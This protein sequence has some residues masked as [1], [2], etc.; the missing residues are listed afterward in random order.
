[1]QVVGAAGPYAQKHLDGKREKGNREGRSREDREEGASGTGSQERLSI[2]EI[3]CKV[4]C[5]FHWATELFR[6][7]IVAPVRAPD[8]A[9]NRGVARHVAQDLT[10]VRV[11][12][13]PRKISFPGSQRH[14]DAHPYS[15]RFQQTT[16]NI[17]LAALFIAGSF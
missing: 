11:Y 8:T 12:R 16:L 7:I 17:P 1:M 13:L 9:R 5:Y 3:T 4:S 15:A 2:L 6:I 14:C 10:P